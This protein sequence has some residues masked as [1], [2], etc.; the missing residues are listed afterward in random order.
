MMINSIIDPIISSTK[1]SDTKIVI[2]AKIKP[3]T[4][5]AG[6]K[7][8]AALSVLHKACHALLNELGSFLN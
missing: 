1:Y 2:K 5:T 7:P 8:Y 3:T 6:A 4:T